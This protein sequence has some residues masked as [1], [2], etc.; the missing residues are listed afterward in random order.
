MKGF[1]REVAWFFIAVILAIPG[2][3]FFMYLMNLSPQ[4]STISSFEEVFEM[5]LFIIGAIIS[6][7]CAYIIR[8]IIWAMVKTFHTDDT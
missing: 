1:A 4:G 5:E 2:A 8:I 6:F 7:F 3:Y